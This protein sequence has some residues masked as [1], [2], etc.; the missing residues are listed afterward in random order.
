MAE[1][2]LSASR[3]TLA[4]LDAESDTEDW[5][6]FGGWLGASAS[7]RTTAEATGLEDRDALVTIVH[8]GCGKGDVVPAD[9][10]HD[11]CLFSKDRIN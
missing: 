8:K 4:L 5:R 10:S 2:L 9:I 11:Y 6:R 1:E 3:N 7:G